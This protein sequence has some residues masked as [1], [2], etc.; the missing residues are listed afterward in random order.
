M[1]VQLIPR[2]RRPHAFTAGMVDNKL[3]LVDTQQ[4]TA[5]PVFD[6]D[7]FSRPGTPAM[8]QLLRMNRQNGPR[9]SISGLLCIV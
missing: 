7:A 9:I 1:E 4:G 2:D 6:F 3:Y 8:P 5:T